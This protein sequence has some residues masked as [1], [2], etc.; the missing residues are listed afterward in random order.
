MTT[1]LHTISVL[2]VTYGNRWQYLKQVLK[3]VLN[4][5]QVT[6][7]VVVD[8]ASDYNV[9][10]KVKELDDSR[11]TVITNAQ[12]EGSA[13]GYNAAIS[14]AVKSA[15][16]D[17]L[18]LLDDDNLPADNA[19]DLLLQKWQSIEPNNNRKALFCLREDRPAHVKIAKGES[20][21]RYYLVPNNFLGFS[22]FNIL[23]N[24]VYKLRD[25]LNKQQAYLPQA[26]IP[27]VPYGG[28]MFHQSTVADIGLPDKDMFVYVDDSEYTYRITQNGGTIWLIPSCKITDL[29]PSQG[30]GY[31]PR[32]FHSKLLNQWSFRTYYHVRNRLYFYSKVAIKN[33]IAFKINKTLYLTYLQ[34]VSLLSCKVNEYKKL[35]QAVNDGLNANLGKADKDK[36]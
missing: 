23:R 33:K 22:V 3:R 32:L 21:Y 13:G 28:L 30:V 5:A 17:L 11:I 20:P 19:L 35:L 27:Y 4:S 15:Q 2:T 18:W 7:I 12:N 34:I 31:Q 36:F 29:E 24:R 14:Y 1:Q 9:A 16:A 25:K 6:Q 26:S 10:D 8:N